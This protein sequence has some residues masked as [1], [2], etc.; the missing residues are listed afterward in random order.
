MYKAK[1]FCLISG[2]LCFFTEVSAQFDKAN[3]KATELLVFIMP[4][5]LELAPELKRGASIQQSNIKSQ[6][7]KTTL[8]TVKVNFIAKAFP[9]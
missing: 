9:N 7:L 3:E 8:E 1:I 4:D 2:L 6:G 5:S